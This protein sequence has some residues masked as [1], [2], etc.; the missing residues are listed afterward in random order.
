MRKL[1]ERPWG[2]G[3][4]S[5]CS[6]TPGQPLPNSVTPGGSVTLRDGKVD[7]LV[8]V[9]EVQGAA[10]AGV[11]EEFSGHDGPACGGQRLGDRITF[12]EANVF[13]CVL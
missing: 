11:I 7:I 12:A 1:L 5:G 8:R 13:I 10:L 9:T 3:I 4:A 2:T 6:H